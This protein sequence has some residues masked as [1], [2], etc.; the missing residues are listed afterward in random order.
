M[1]KQRP[2]RFLKPARSLF[3]YLYSYYYN[4]WYKK[5]ASADDQMMVQ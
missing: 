3:L 1:L 2:G 5:S 4:K